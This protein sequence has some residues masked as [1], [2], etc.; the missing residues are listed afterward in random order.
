MACHLLGAAEALRNAINSPRPPR[1]QEKHQK[2]IAALLSLLGP[3]E[4]YATWAEGQA[5]TW[6]Q[7]VAFALEEP[8]P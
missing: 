4:F 3:T 8:A 5:M 1:A 2:Q 7:A 6:E